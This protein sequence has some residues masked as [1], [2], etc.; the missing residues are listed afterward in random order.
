MP[1]LLSKP[2]NPKSTYAVWH[3]KET[4][5]QLEELHEEVAPEALMNKQAEWLV[6]RILTKHLCDIHHQKYK[7][8]EKNKE[9]KPRLIGSKIHISITH[10]W[11]M[12][13]VLINEMEPCGIDLELPR[14]KLRLV[15]PR[16]VNNG[17]KED[18]LDK[19][20]QIWA[21]KE[22]VY[23]IYGRKKLSLKD[24]LRSQ[25]LTD[26]LLEIENLKEP[27]S[28]HFQIA[29]EKINDYWLAFNQ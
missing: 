29:V 9:G 16:F 23:K 17:E 5:S 18:D 27:G 1:I 2:I 13:A 15:S 26:N 28:K 8:I 20:C 6:T 11:P 10:S 24:D 4:N 14:E 7:G 19:L 22:V 25:F 3:I 12:A 21:A